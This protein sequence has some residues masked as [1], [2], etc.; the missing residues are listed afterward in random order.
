M[1]D[2]CGMDA[3]NCLSAGLKQLAMIS[4]DEALI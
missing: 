2:L 4:L 1:Q 3:N